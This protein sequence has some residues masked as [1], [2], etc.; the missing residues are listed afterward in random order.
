M[1]LCPARPAEGCLLLPD[2]AG[3]A[4]PAPGATILPTARCIVI[5][6]PG[7]TAFHPLSPV[8]RFR[9]NKGETEVNTGHKL[10]GPAVPAGRG[11][12]ARRHAGARRYDTGLF[13]QAEAARGFLPPRGRFSIRVSPSR[14]FFKLAVIEIGIKPPRAGNCSW[15]PCPTI[16]PSFQTRIRSAFFMA[17]KR[18]AMTKLVRCSVS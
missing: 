9:L 7:K 6:L 16:S 14:N 2:A 3:R 18:R 17:D 5:F 13:Q 10:Y 15:V 12:G 4:P 11:N 1:E 8:Y